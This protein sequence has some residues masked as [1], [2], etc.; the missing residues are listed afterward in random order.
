MSISLM[1]QIWD[2]EDPELTGSRLVILLSLADHANDAGECW[3][4][5]ERI[6]TRVRLSP[7]N[8]M[9]QLDELERIG[10]LTIR[11]SIG[12]HNTY[13]VH[14]TPDASVTGD[15]N[16]TPDASVTGTPDASVTPPLTPASPEPLVNHQINR[17][18]N[19]QSAGAR[20]APLSK[21]S[22]TKPTKKAPPEILPAPAQ[23][24]VEHGGKWPPGKLADG[25]SKK[26]RAVAYIC[27]H[28]GS[29][30]ESLRLWG[31]VVAGYCAQWSPR[32]Y[33]VMIQDY[34]L[35]GKVPGERKNGNGKSAN[36]QSNFGLAS[37]TTDADRAYHAANSPEAIAALQ[38][39]FDAARAAR[40]ARG[41][42]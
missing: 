35:A 30:S 2:N 10:Y 27:E 23:T 25:T 26:A 1:A 24:F 38:A 37:L 17:Q 18:V 20:A 9:R 4:S 28:V 31:R 8:V 6:A 12:R 19:H 41:V 36:S 42:S 21:P 14:R 13:V 3:P 40:A 33:T 34:Y 16:V 5:I 11:R 22:A 29:D 7:R 39:E 32:S 15:K